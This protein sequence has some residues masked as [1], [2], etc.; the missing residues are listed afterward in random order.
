M[1]ELAEGDPS[2]DEYLASWDSILNGGIRIN[3]ANDAVVSVKHMF[4]PSFP[5]NGISALTD[6]VPGYLD[7]SYNWL[8]WNGKPMDGTVRLREKTYIDSLDVNFLQDACHWI[9]PPKEVRM[10]VS[11]DGI[12]FKEIFRH[13]TKK[14]EKD[15]KVRKV[16]FNV[17][18]RR[19]IL[20]VRIYAAPQTS[21]PPWRFVPNRQ[22][23]FACDEIWL[24]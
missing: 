13:K 4:D 8:I 3:K 20:A 23:L 9:F 7:F 11:T 17:S 10:F 22:P 16:R 21:L 1:R 6:S 2:P 12:H 18:V 5:A 14:I 24:E 15:D 19:D